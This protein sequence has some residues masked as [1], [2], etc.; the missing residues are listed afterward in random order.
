[1]TLK[2]GRIYKRKNML[3]NS[4]LLSIHEFNSIFRHWYKLI[5]LARMITPIFIY[6]IMWDGSL[7]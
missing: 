6:Y 7:F 4:H 1:M 2:L 5:L 3:V